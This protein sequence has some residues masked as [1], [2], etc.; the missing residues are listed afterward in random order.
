[1]YPVVIEK[2]HQKF[3]RFHERCAHRV[4]EMAPPELIPVMHEVIQQDVAIGLKTLEQEL[5]SFL[6]DCRNGR[7]EE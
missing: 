7:R 5:S 3:D 4:A 6:D 1:M 2:L